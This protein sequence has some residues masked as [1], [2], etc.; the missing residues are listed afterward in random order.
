MKKNNEKKINWKKVA[1]VG[2]VFVL[3][4]ATG[5]IGGK[6]HLSTS[7]IMRTFALT[8]PDAC[9]EGKVALNWL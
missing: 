4:A 9:L 5:V 7:S 2:G 1:I 8:K 3:G 6:R